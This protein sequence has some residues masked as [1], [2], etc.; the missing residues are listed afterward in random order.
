MSILEKIE[1]GFIL[2]FSILVWFLPLPEQ[3]SIDRLTLWIFAL[4]LL[5]SLIRDIAILFTQKKAQATLI[6][7]PKKSRCM[8]LESTLGAS[9]MGLG[10]STAI[11]MK[12][13][14]WSLS[15]FLYELRVKKTRTTDKQR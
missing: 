5:Q 9:L 15:I 4:L 2:I 14:A 11:E 12:A 1:L 8:C 3:I 6:E 10:I 7:K 13:I